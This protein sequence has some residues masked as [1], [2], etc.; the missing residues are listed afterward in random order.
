LT[1]QLGVDTGG[2]YTDAVLLHEQT[3]GVRKAKAL[4]T[5]GHLI[6]G[7]RGALDSVLDDVDVADI[8]LVSLSTT[9]ATNALV[10]GKGR[11]VALLLVGYSETQM[12]RAGLGA[13]LAGDP[14]A[15]V[16][17][18]HSAGG[19]ELEPLDIH[20]AESFIKDVADQVDAFAV[21]AM[22]AV[23]NPGHELALLHTISSLTAKPVSLGHHLSSGLDAPRRALTCLFNARLIPSIRA[24]LEAANTW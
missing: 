21:S 12:S 14:I 3:Q 2:T 20:V 18:G 6:D 17:G 8:N 10:E 1:L 9:L 5:H 4:T 19:D 13:A 15:F 22:F 7:L 11:R 16:A 23:R 24:L